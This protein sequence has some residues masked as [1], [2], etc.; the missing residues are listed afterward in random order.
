MRS[1]M[2][3]FLQGPLS[4]AMPLI[5]FDPHSILYCR[6]VRFGGIHNNVSLPRIFILFAK[7]PFC[8][9][10]LSLPVFTCFLSDISDYNTTQFILPPAHYWYFVV[11]EI[12]ILWMLISYVYFIAQVLEIDNKARIIKNSVVAFYISIVI[13]LL[14]HL[15]KVF[16][17]DID[18]LSR[19]Y[20]FIV[21]W[22]WLQSLLLV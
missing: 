21:N 10:V 15:F 11:D 16:F 20:F 22:F 17:T 12:F 6:A 13:S 3:H 4:L 19:T 9:I 14:A 1:F 5:D 18:F 2:N 7:G 8:F